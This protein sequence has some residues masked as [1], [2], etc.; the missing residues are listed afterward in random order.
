MSHTT[1]FVGIPKQIISELRVNLGSVEQKYIL[2]TLRENPATNGLLTISLKPHPDLGTF[3]TGDLSIDGQIIVNISSD[4]QV[5]LDGTY[6]DLSFDMAE[7]LSGI[8]N[9][10]AGNNF[11]PDLISSF[12]NSNIGLNL[13]IQ[14]GL[15]TLSATVNFD[16]TNSASVISVIHLYP[17]VGR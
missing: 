16:V 5:S 13:A 14:S 9:P 3:N 17:N 1:D 2:V 8:Q 6:V 11:L 15:P 7:A 4:L 10:T 12:S